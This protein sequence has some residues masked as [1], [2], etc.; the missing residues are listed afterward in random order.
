[1]VPGCPS[2]YPIGMRA[3]PSFLLAVFATAGFAVAACSS[4]GTTSPGTD[5]AAD[6][7]STDDAAAETGPPPAA[8]VI[9]N[10]YKY[11]PS[12]LTV[13][14]GDTVR[15]RFTKGTHS[16]TSGTNCTKAAGTLELDSGE[17]GSPFTYDH[18][19]TKEGTYPY[20]CTYM[21]HCSMFGQEGTVTVT[22]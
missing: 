21:Q 18:T 13:K 7:A 15:W 17:S 2:C 3:L 4:G 8:T 9:V 19:F 12:T 14:V 16:V 11:V 6:A 10:D 20:F 5:A 1:M 22:P